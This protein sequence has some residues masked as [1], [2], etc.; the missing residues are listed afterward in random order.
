MN[1]HAYLHVR[2][3]KHTE[4]YKIVYKFDFIMISS[5]KIQRFNKSMHISY[6]IHWMDEPL[7]LLL[8]L[9]KKWAHIVNKS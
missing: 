6:E 1:M 2:I 5:V 9:Y 8:M 4:L 7:Q 3:Y